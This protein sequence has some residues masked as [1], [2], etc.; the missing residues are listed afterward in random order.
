MMNSQAGRIVIGYDGSTH[1]QVA[2]D[3][4]AAEARRRDLPLTVLTVFDQVAAVPI[5]FGGSVWPAMFEKEAIELA[6]AGARR[7]RTIAMSSEVTAATVC[8]QVAYGLIKASQEAALLVVGTRGHG[9]F[10]GTVLGS[11]AFAVSAH[12]HCPVVVVR[13]EAQ[14]LPGPDRPVVVGVDESAGS[15]AAVRFAADVA[16]DTG[17][18]LI[19]ASAYL[20]SASQVWAQATPGLETDG[21]VSFDSVVRTAATEKASGAIALA[22]ALH[23][24]LAV[25]EV[26]IDGRAADALATTAKGCGLLVVGSRGRG[27]FAGLMLGSVSHEVIHSAP[28]PAACPSVSSVRKRSTARQCS[29]PGRITA[30]AVVACPRTA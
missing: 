14:Q 18:P 8:S 19:V 24:A 22:Q 23:P 11:V 26:V 25:Q 30:T 10:A 21:T 20:S 12:A 6:E 15:Q 2:L 29:R 17:A 4:A 28:C 5:T 9:E 3:W 1:S 7:A 13:G 16:A 27:G